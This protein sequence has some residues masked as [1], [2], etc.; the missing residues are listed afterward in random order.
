MVVNVAPYRRDGPLA[1]VVMVMVVVV[2]VHLS[3]AALKRLARCWFILALGATPS[4][5]CKVHYMSQPLLPT[6]NFLKA[7]LTGE[8]EEDH[9]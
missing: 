7:N 3:C 1:A 9:V 8:G 6:H 4:I 5:A 2:V